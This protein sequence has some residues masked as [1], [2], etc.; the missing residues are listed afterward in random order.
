MAAKF[1][2][3]FRFAAANAADAADAAIPSLMALGFGGA[4]GFG[5]FAFC[6]KTG[7]IFCAKIGFVIEKRGFI[8]SGRTGGRASDRTAVWRENKHTVQVRKLN[9]FGF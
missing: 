8:S 7:L 3:N 2:T 9:T 1:S 5:T 6:G 4:F